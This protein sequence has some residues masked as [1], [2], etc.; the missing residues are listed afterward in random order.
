MVCS[1]AQFYDAET[2]ALLLLALG[3]GDGSALV[4]ETSATTRA[5]SQYP[6]PKLNS[7]LTQV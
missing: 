6:N 5:K 7:A 2:I 4:Q 1:H 3:G